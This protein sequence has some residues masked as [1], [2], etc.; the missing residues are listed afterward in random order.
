MVHLLQQ[1]LRVALAPL[2]GQAAVE[3]AVEKRLEEGFEGGGGGGY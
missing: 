3:G 1:L 2:G